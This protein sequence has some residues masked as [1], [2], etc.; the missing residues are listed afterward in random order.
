MFSKILVPVDTSD[1]S[2]KAVD[3]ALSLADRFGSEVIL[4]HIRPAKARLEHGAV[5][6][7]LDAIEAQ[8][9][10]LLDI[11]LGKLGADHSVTPERVTSEVRAGPVAEVIGL[12][13]EDHMV[14]VIVMGTHGRHRVTELFTG[15][16]A[17]QVVAKTSAS[18]LVVKPEG[19]PFLRD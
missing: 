6:A 15:S 13:A 17:E 9:G 10:R 16:T 14:D 4:L 18:V 2:Q 8:S 11:G 19:F 7:D 3:A 1:I 12:A 5:E